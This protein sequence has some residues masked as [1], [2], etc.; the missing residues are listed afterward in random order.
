M[1]GYHVHN[2][3]Y[4]EKIDHSLSFFKTVSAVVSFF[5]LV[6][7][8]GHTIPFCSTFCLTDFE[9]WETV[10]S[11]PLFKQTDH[12]HSSRSDEKKEKGKATILRKG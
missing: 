3:N 10:H 8:L 5:F 7:G 2:Q 6:S 11:L 4:E 9:E 1:K 12:S